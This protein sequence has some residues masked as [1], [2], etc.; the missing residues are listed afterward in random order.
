MSIISEKLKSL[1]IALPV[2]ASPVAAYAPY[3]ITGNLVFVSGQ[4]PLEDGKV[5]FT[6]MLGKDMD[7]ARGYEAARLCGLNILAQLN[8]ACGGDLGKVEACV[9]LG[10]FVASAPDFFD[11]PQVVNGASELMEA[12]FGEKGKHARFAVGVASLP[13]NAA[14]EVDA[15]FALRA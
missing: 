5:K 10:G 2:P 13:K 6:G 9:K 15:V 4:I 11:H 14:V 7:T 1:G 3:V 8:A 12:V